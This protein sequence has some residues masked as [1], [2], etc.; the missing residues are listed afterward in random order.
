MSPRLSPAEMAEL[1]RKTNAA[2]SAAE[3]NMQTTFGKQLN[4]TQNDLLEKIRGFL[5]QAREAARA[6]DWQR[7]LNLAEK[8]QVLSV[9][10]VNSL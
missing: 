1:E 3:K 9:E 5:G 2:I 8:A 10:L 4:A 7:A 6:G